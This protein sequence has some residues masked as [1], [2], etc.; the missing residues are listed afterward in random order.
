MKYFI[1][2]R[3]TGADPAYLEQ[4]LPAIREAFKSSG[5]EV[6]CTYFDEDGFKAGG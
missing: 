4:L 1:A 6:Y 2:Y 5:L 3:H